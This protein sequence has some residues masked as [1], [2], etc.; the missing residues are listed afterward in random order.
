[1]VKGPKI[2]V[3]IPVYNV[4]DYLSRSLES[5][6]RQTL[7]DIEIICVNDGSTDNSAEIIREQM[8]IDSRIQL[9]NKENAGVA[10]A[11]N[12]GIDAATGDMIMFLDPDDYLAVN[13]CERVYE[14]RINHYA[15]IIVYGSIPFPEIP[16]PD[17]WVV[18]KLNSRDMYYPEPDERSLFGETN[19][20]PFIWNHAY[21]RDFLNDN[22]LR[23]EESIKFGEDIVF[24][25]E[26]VPLAQRV[27]YISDRLH[28]YQCYRSGSFMQQYN[29]EAE[30][31]LVQHVKNL[32]T[33]T[34]FWNEK[35][36]LTKWGTAYFE[37]F[38][39][40]IEPDLIQFNPKNKQKLALETVKI[41]EKYNLKRFYGHSRMEIKEK[42]KRL[43]K[44]AKSGK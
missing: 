24:L 12:T 32:R 18:W 33:I 17:A 11:R 22:H 6:R 4:A 16:E 38:I 29:G 8:A 31:R 35:E 21:S 37:W 9:I 25:F 7:L 40:F 36:L 44:M 26:T 20:E 15:D 43:Y 19:S 23:F 3:I 5:L 30:K 39:D 2:S 13:A 34:M 14:E 27:Q 42:T 1:M 28:Y 10:A 41:I